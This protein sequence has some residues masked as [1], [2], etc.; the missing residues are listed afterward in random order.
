MTSYWRSVDFF[1]AG[2]VGE[3]EQA[4]SMPFRG[5]SKADSSRSSLSGL[6]QQQEFTHKRDLLGFPEL[7]FGRHVLTI[8]ACLVY[9]QY[10]NVKYC[11]LLSCEFGTVNE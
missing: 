7:V 10:L 1:P 5:R 3:L 11:H 9:L 6:V 4:N 2:V 8:S